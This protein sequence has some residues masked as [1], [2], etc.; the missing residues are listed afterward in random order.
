MDPK[1]VRNLKYAKKGNKRSGAGAIV[2]KAAA[3]KAEKPEKKAASTKAPAKAAAKPA[4]KAAS[5]KDVKASDHCF[6]SVVFTL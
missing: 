2:K 3:D 1:F 5:T 4:P 6:R